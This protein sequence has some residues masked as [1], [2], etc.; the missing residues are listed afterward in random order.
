MPVDGAV[1]WLLGVVEDDQ[2]GPEGESEPFPDRR[3]TGAGGGLGR[4]EGCWRS[5]VIRSRR[6]WGG[7]ARVLRAPGERRHSELRLHTDPLTPGCHQLP[8]V[9]LLVPRVGVGGARMA[10]ADRPA[11]WSSSRQADGPTAAE[12]DVGARD[13]SSH[14]PAAPRCSLA[15]SPD[16][17]LLVLNRL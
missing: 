3:G 13:C 4:F 8:E 11:V 6:L 5:L 1:T 15:V 16:I 10:G 2:A 12:G 17:P 7:G 14:P 9:L